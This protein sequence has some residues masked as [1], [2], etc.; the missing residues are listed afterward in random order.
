MSNAQTNEAP[1]NELQQAGAYKPPSLGVQLK[2][3]QANFA[4]ALPAHIPVARFMRVVL[5]AVQNSPDLLKA[6][7][8]SLLNACLRAAQDGLLPDGRDGALVVYNTKI[9]GN[10]VAK[11]QWMVMVGGIRKKARNSGEIATWDVHAAH[12]KDQF[13]FELGDEPY[14]KHKP[15]IPTALAEKEGEKPED[16]AARYKIHCDRGPMIAVYS[17]A[18]LKSGE[19]SRDVMLASDVYEVRDKFSKRTKD[20]QFS[21]AWRNSLVEMAKKTVARRHSKVL[22]M[23]SDLDDL[24]R[25]DD[26][27]YDMEGNSDRRL[28]KGGGPSKSIGDRIDALIGAVGEEEEAAAAGVGESFDP[29]TGEISQAA[30]NGNGATAEPSKPKPTEP[31]KPTAPAQAADDIDPYTGKPLSEEGPANSNAPA[32]GGA[33]A[34]T[35][36]APQEGAQAASGTAA[37]AAPANPQDTL[38]ADLRATAKG[39]AQGGVAALRNF[40]DNLEPGERAMLSDAEVRELMTVAKGVKG[41]AK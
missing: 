33:T 15:F 39:R 18:V 20:G 10:W 22:P 2:E 9:N 35:S 6:D 41:P 29:E 17:V 11:V 30:T 5:T 16:Y 19:K 34:E 26:E 27:L 8:H 40:L 3:K 4:A 13:E 14:I 31:V 21:P 7:R 38:L 25:R 28:T 36:Q 23:S 24:V 37:T 32:Q 12:A 1:R